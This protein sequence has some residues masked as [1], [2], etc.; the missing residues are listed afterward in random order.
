MSAPTL[1]VDP[2]ATLGGSGT[3]GRNITIADGGKLEFNLGTPAAS[4]VPLTRSSSRTMAFS[5]SSVLTIT[6]GAS[7]APGLYT[8]I[9]GGNNITGSAPATVIL[10]PGWTADAPV[11]STNQ[12]RINITNVVAPPANAAPVW[13]QQSGQ[14]SQC[15]RGCRL[16]RHARQ[17][18]QRLEQRCADLPESERSR[19]AQ[20]RHQRHALRHAHQQR[21]RRE[22]LHRERQ[23][24]ALPPAVQAT[25]NITVTNINDAPVWSSNPLV[26]PDATEDAA[27]SQ[28]MATA[29]S[30]V[31]AG[32]VLTFAK[33]SG[34]SWLSVAANGTIS[35]TPANAD[36]GLNVFTVSVSD[37]IAAPVETT[38]QITVINTND[39]PFW[40][41]NP[42]T[43]GNTVRDLP[44]TGSLAGSAGDV[45]PGASLTFSKLSGPRMAE[46]RSNGALSGV[47]RP[48]AT[49]A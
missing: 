25:L 13:S 41:I 21:C 9:T 46:R 15:H 33:V 42:I 38:L 35:G 49:S 20:H 11:I 28:N 22:H 10:P 48:S 24:M 5:G 19:M 8:L 32:A 43:G 45:D 2:G 18:C 23:P 12:L 17:R 37:G 30:D 14:R 4:H 40:T 27:Y 39:A 26:G 3:V 47:P 44:Y 1:T 29:A 16:Q 34:P 36:V 6:A 31:D 7:A